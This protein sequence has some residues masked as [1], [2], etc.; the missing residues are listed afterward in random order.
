MQKSRAAPP[1]RGTLLSAKYLEEEMR[2]LILVAALTLPTL[3]AAA[4]REFSQGHQA[5]QRHIERT[6]AYATYKAVWLRHNRLLLSADTQRVKAKALAKDVCRLL[7]QNGFTNM[8]VAVAVSDHQQ[9]RTS[10]TFDGK[11]ERYCER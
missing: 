1:Q 9:L 5:L 2:Y 3:S 10:N 11:A 4:E 7:L 6:P 8:D